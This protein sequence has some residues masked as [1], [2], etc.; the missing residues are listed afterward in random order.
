M[1]TDRCGNTRGQNCH[2]KGSGKD[3]KIQELCKEIQR[4][5]NLKC[6]IIPVING[7]TGIVTKGLKEEFGIHARKNF[8]R[9]TTKD[10]YTWN[11]THH[12]GSKTF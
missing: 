11:I 8:N 6:E 4:M 7:A 5:C 9:F 1:H 2:A 10:S 12:T 3:G